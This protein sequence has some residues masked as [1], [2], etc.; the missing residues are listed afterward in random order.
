MPQ[1]DLG[2]R[3]FAYR[4]R[5]SKR[6]KNI[7]L[8]YSPSNGLELVYPAGTHEPAPETFLAEKTGWILRTSEKF[9]QISER[10]PARDYIDGEVFFIR[11]LEHRLKL[12][13]A[14]LQSKI[15]VWHSE[16]Y[17]LLAYPQQD[18]PPDKESLRAAVT[19]FY[20]AQARSYL[21]QH[22]AE[23]ATQH[24]F[25]YQQVRIK[26]QKTRW[27]SCSSKGNINLNLRLM[28]APD[29]A[30]DYVM[31]HE[32]CHLQEMNHSQSFWVLLE[33]HCPDYRHWK[34]WFKQHG[35]SLR[36]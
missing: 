21:P 3:T 11:G 15:R 5:V 10:F 6:A 27:G 17:L 9:R 22:L 2:G 35:P 33:S 32:L 31:L 24:G 13:C 19:S 18:D 28:M 23:L 14:P 30:I 8:R 7:I 36:L 29:A 26:N 1:I 25:R 34:A 12:I 4:V 20:R 16:G